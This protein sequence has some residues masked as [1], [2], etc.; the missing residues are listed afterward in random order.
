MKL[1]HFGEFDCDSTATQFEVQSQESLRGVSVGSQSIAN[2]PQM[3]CELIS[4]NVQQ[5][6]YL[7]SERKVPV[8]EG[9]IEQKK[10]NLEDKLGLLIPKKQY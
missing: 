8:E 4:T 7:F 5:Q 10:S 1:S 2:L 3:R 6:K 9:E